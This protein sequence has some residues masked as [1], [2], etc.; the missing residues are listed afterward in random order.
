MPAS[1]AVVDLAAVGDERDPQAERGLVALGDLLQ[2]W[3]CDSIFDEYELLEFFVGHA[4]AVDGA[5]APAPEEAPRPGYQPLKVWPSES[6]GWLERH[7]SRCPIY[8]GDLAPASSEAPDR[9]AVIAL[10]KSIVSE[11]RGLEE[12][13]RFAVRR[14]DVVDILIRERKIVPAFLRGPATT[15]L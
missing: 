12:L 5:V 1:T 15:G 13:R 14:Q 3:A 11:R 10:L 4:D 9:G 7:A 8:D 2:R 6:R